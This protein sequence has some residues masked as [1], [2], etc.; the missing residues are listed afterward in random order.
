MT[1]DIGQFISETNQ[2]KSVDELVL[3]LE[4]HFHI[5]GIETFLISLLNDHPSFGLPARHGI[6][7]SYPEDWMKHYFKQSYER[8]DPVR[9]ECSKVGAFSWDELMKQERFS[10]KQRRMM[11]EAAEAG[12]K[13]GVA[14]GVCSYN[15]QYA[16]VG[17]ASNH[18]FEITKNKIDLLNLLAVHSTQCFLHLS[19]S[20]EKSMPAN[21]V[22][23]LTPQQHEVLKWIAAGM[24]PHD[25]ADKLVINKKTVDFHLENIYRK[26]RV[27]SRAQ[28]ISKA[29][30]LGL[31][32]A[33]PELLDL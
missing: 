4:K 30:Q 25:V 32:Q 26:L 21:K 14:V 29:L 22:P 13:H 7:R 2:T 19:M 28:A 1:F 12:L 3:A 15:G 18:D 24:A 6:I 27:C 11:N 31:V 5:L 16:G 33:Y 9:L 17:F 8:I 23:V 10:Y 20:K